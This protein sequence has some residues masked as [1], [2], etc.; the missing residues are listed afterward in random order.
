MCAGVFHDTL[1]RHLSDGRVVDKEKL[2]QTKLKVSASLVNFV[3]GGGV[4][5]FEGEERDAPP[6][7]FAARKTA[8][9]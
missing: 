3:V 2:E 4:L 6:D 1:A 5:L 9:P 7:P 8:T